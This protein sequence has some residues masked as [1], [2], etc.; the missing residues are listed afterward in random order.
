MGI[1]MFSSCILA[2]AS[3]EASSLVVS[4]SEVYVSGGSAVECMRNKS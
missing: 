2:F 1:E 3:H 4:K